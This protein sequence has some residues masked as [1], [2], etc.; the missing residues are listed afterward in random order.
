MKISK[1]MSRTEFAAAVVKCLEGDGISCVLVGGS[2]VSIYTDERHHSKD[3]D[4]ISPYS[5]AAITK[6]L[7][8]LGFEKEGRYYNHKNSDFYVEF[9]SGPPAI[10]NEIPVEPE[11]K[12][13]VNDVTI[14]LYSPTQCVMDR[15]AAWYHWRDRN[16]LLQAIWVAE[17]HPIKIQK[18][19]SWSDREGELE[20]FNEFSKLL[21]S[22]KV[23]PKKMK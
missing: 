8:R 20:K 21:R 5:V 4:F 1:K 11:G 22:G 14:R 16:S 19:K 2:C 13:I 10:G 3:L 17:K 15:L 23:A 6:S 9:P 7:A 18:V 12:I